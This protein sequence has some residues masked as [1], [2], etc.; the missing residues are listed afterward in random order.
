MLV[1]TIIPQLKPFELLT[2]NELIR[3][4]LITVIDMVIQGQ[5]MSMLQIIQ[6]L[7]N[8]TWPIVQQPTIQTVLYQFQAALNKLDETMR[9]IKAKTS[10]VNTGFK[11]GSFF[12]GL[13]KSAVNAA[14]AVG[15]EFGL[16]VGAANCFNIDFQQGSGEIDYERKYKK[17]KQK[18]LKL[19]QLRLKN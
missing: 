19:K 1:A 8:D 16:P 17:Y 2:K 18:Y 4:A 13:A 10:Q 3:Q 14:V 12:K 7:N 9:N 15:S 11:V 6:K 5:N